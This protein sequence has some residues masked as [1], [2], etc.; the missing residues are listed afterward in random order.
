[1]KIEE[2]KGLVR[3]IES[4][5]EI[6]LLTILYYIFWLFGYDD[7][8]I[9]AYYGNG[10]YVLMGVYALVAYVL[11]RNSDC[12]RFGNLR[13]LDLCIAQWI[14]LVLVNVITYFQLC[15]MANRMISV[16]PIVYLLVAQGIAAMLLIMLYARIYNRLYAPRNVVMIY[17][18]EDAMALKRKI[19]SRKDKYRIQCC[20]PASVGLEELYRQIRN[21]EAV[22]INDVPAQ[23]RNDIIKHCYQNKIRVYMVPKLS[24]ILIRGATNMTIFDTPMVLIKGTGPT[25]FQRFMK[26]VMDI[27]IS[28]VVMVVFAP[29]MLVVAAA[30]KLEDKGPVFFTQK[31]VTLNGREFDIIKFRSMVTDAEKDGCPV[32]ATED[33]PR[34][35]RVGRIIRR[36]RIDELPQIINV[37]RGDMSFVGPRPERREFVE[38]YS[39]DI[40]EFNFRLKVKGGITGY[41]QIYG[42][43]NT[44]AYDKLRMDLMYIENYSL[45]LDI[46]L[47]LLTLR[48]M[49]NKEST[50]G[51]P[52]AEIPAE[53]ETPV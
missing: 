31:R 28:L 46:K 23:M 40:P 7:S 14:A 25:V 12:F 33:D 47:I 39:R 10:K 29:V 44:T 36:T 27:A 1:M 9:P 51:F 3:G 16:L 48:I 43:Y 52:A 45:L 22:V 50:E 35:T 34:I 6:A 21:Y 32:P 37:L 4:V 18:A 42:K 8:G 15:L 17:G 24:D 2:N 49:F 5:A 53:E 26:R 41:A 11:F 30:I 19:E 20:L 13:R 38:Q